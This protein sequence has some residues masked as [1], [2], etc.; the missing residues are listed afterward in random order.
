MLKTIGYILFGIC[1]ISFLSI[2]IVP[3]LGFTA[4]QVAGITVALIIIGEATFYLSLI[5]LGKGFYD[6][7][8]SKLKFRK[9]KSDKDSA[10]E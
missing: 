10:Q 2:L 9:S 8:K 3:L 5:F 4:K 7:I 6:K 1:T